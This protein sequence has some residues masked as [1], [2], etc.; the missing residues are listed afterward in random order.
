VPT[1]LEQVFAAIGQAHS[2]VLAA[3]DR[4]RVLE[5]LLANLSKV[6]GVRIGR[7]QS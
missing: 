4:N 2:E 6:A 5:A 1:R 3:L 7:W